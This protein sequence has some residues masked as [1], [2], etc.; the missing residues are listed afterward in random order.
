MRNENVS[1][2]EAKIKGLRLS[3]M[4]QLLY[5]K[6]GRDI[7]DSVRIVGFVSRDYDGG[8]SLYLSDMSP[9]CKQSLGRDRGYKIEQIEQLLRLSPSEEKANLV[10][11]LI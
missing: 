2:I 3:D 7:G 5:F 4:V 6:G 8:G 10:K 9:R 1:Y 11:C